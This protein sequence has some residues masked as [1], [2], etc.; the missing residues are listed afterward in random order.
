MDFALQ[1]T[2]EFLNRVLGPTAHVERYSDWY[3]RLRFRNMLG[4]YGRAII[5]KW[6]GNPNWA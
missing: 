4:F 3:V 6:G 5:L 2:R 1:Q